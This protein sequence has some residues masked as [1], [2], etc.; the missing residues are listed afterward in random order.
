M[1]PPNLIKAILQAPVDL[2]FNGGIGTYIKAES[3]PTPTSVTAPTIR[4][5]STVLRSAP[6]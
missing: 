4:C 3:N 6:R 5:G 1:T 2:L